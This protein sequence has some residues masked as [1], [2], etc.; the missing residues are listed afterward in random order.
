MTNKILA[1]ELLEDK[2]RRIKKDTK[3]IEGLT[4]RSTDYLLLRAGKKGKGKKIHEVLY[5]KD[6]FVEINYNEYE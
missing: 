3:I 1:Q 2:R 4:K 5:S 6:C